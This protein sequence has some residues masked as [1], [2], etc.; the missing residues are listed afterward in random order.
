[1]STAR[2]RWI[3]TLGPVLAV[4]LLDYLLHGF[5]HNIVL[6][7]GG[8]LLVLLVTFVGA[9]F[10]SRF[11]FSLVDRMQKELLR[12]NQ[13]LSALNIVALAV[14]KSLHLDEVLRRALDTVLEVTGTEAGEI[15]LKEERTGDFV[16]H[17][18]RGLFREAFQQKTRFSQEEG[19]PGLVSR[20]G[21]SLTVDNLAGDPRFLRKAVIEVGFRS[22]VG[23]P[24][25]SRGQII[26]ILGVAS[27]KKR[28]FPSEDVNLLI[29]IGGQISLAIENARLHGQV[30]SAAAVE[31][32][33][34]I[35]REMHDG[36]GQLLGYINAQT[37]ALKKLLSDGRLA[38]AQNE[39]TEMEESA[40]DLY[41][42]V[43]EGIFGLR[44]AGSWE[45]G[46]LTLL[47]EYVERYREMSGLDARLE[48]A[49]EMRGVQLPPACEIQLIRIVQEALT[50][51]RKHSRAAAVGIRLNRD[52][53][54][55]RIEVSDNGEGFDPAVQ[56]SRGWPRFGIQ[57]MR[58]RA[59]AVG[60]ELT[61]ETS[62]GKGTCV[63]ILG[64][65]GEPEGGSYASASGG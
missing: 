49:P 59:Q 29:A 48:I 16:Q 55:F 17:M 34:R 40:R 44:M 23:V 61:I 58:E 28:P 32:R 7:W 36:M 5:L 47:R 64:P 6:L 39:L 13:E 46:F 18:H 53:D 43:R 22:F 10:F 63:S 50:N 45:K 30:Q 8:V 27:R 41:A 37:L 24:L 56:S 57:T 19:Y 60:A 62:R 2:L 25:S 52:G 20:T 4:V 1:M 9:F 35:A 65:C 33:E 3:T 51:V 11:V 38:E 26:G 12:R 42:D 21:K 54:R 15:F 14:A 31:E